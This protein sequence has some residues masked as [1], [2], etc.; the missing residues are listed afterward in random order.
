[1]QI[2]DILQEKGTEVVTIDAGESVHAAIVKVNRHGFGALIVTGEDRRIAGIVTER[3][4]LKCC[5]DS[6]THLENAPAQERPVCPYL[7]KEIMTKDVII[8]VPDDDL[9]YVMGV[10][11]K[12]HIRHLPILDNGKLAGIISLG[13]LISAHFEEN[14][15]ESRTLK[16]YIRVWGHSHS[17]RTS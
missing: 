9:N 6:C 17:S 11:T 5:G 7:V 12:H 1:M 10:M 13:D 14:V 3:D 8:G 15:F 2:K 16:D 4:F